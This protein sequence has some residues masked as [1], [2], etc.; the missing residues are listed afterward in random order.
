MAQHGAPGRL[1]AFTGNDGSGKTTLLEHCAALLA[2]EGKETLVVAMPSREI[3]AMSLFRDFHD[4]P[5]ETI[6][7]HEIRLALTLIASGDRLRLLHLVV[8]PALQRG[9][10]VL[11]DRYAY[12]GLVRCPDSIIHDVTNRFVAPDLV[13]LASCPVNICEQRVRSRPDEATRFYDHDEEERVRDNYLALARAN[14]F[15]VVD[16][17]QPI[18]DCYFLVEERLG[19]VGVG[20]RLPTR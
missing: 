4:A 9:C 2:R 18:S 1:L 3:R 16:T 12:T 6:R 15:C 11:C 8:L 10:W 20:P 13:F 7:S 14:K 19:R 17:S 5:T